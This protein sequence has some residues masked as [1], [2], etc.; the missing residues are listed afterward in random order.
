MS[1]ALILGLLLQATAPP[2]RPAASMADLPAWSKTPAA[3]ELKAAW[4]Q[5]ALRVN[6]A[7]S[8]VIECSVAGDGRLADCA[9]VSETAP[10]FGAAALTLAPKFQMPTRSPS[11]A[12]TAGRTVQFPIRWLGPSTATLPPVVVYDETGRSGSV[13]FNCRV[14]DNRN[15]DNCVVVDARPQGTNLFQVAGEPAL[16]AKPPASAKDWA[17]VLVVV[18]V[19]PR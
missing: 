10:G 19:K 2:Q 9:A 18:E 5:E 1:A 8:A 4:P 17:R 14:R 15:L 16:R 7:G 3:S 12:S 6:F 11:G 13:G